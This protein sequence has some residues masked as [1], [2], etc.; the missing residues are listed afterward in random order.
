MAMHQ[1]VVSKGKRNAN[2]PLHKRIT[3]CGNLA[4]RMATNYN[5]N[6]EWENCDYLLWTWKDYAKRFLVISLIIGLPLLFL[7]MIS[8]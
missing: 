4:P 5:P 1:K 2:R 6:A 8:R 7:W 3:I